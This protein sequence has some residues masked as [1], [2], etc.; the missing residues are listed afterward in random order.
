MRGANHGAEIHHSVLKIARRVLGNEL[1]RNFPQFLPTMGRI[2]WR[3]DIEKAGENRE[4]C[5]LRRWEEICL[6]R[7]LRLRLRCNGQFRVTTAT[8]RDHSEISRR[9]LRRWCWRNGE[10]FALAHNNR[11][12]PR[13]AE[14]PIQSRRQASRWWE[15]AE[16]PIIVRDDG[17]SLGLLEHDFGNQDGVGIGGLAPGEIAFALVR[18]RLRARVEMRWFFLSSNGW[19]HDGIP[20][21]RPG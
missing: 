10:D 13:R 4:R 12:L 5:W 7:K 19:L 2:N 1:C 3:A 6:T 9:I 11:G 14:P 20:R 15:T 8:R 17:S 16:P 18:T 21:L